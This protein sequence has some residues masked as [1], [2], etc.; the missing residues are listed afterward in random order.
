MML[1]ECAALGRMKPI[2]QALG[3]A[4][5]YGV[6]LWTIIQ[7]LH[8]LRAVYGRAAKTFLSL[9]L[10]WPRMHRPRAAGAR[11]QGVR[12]NAIQSEG[13]RR[14]AGVGGGSGSPEWAA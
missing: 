7:D 9:K 6:Q 5:G 2:E 12:V 14:F 13:R 4:A 11:F 1:D 8:R 3:L 10:L